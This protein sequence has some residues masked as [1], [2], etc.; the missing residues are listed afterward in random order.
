MVTI[1][2]SQRPVDAYA[3]FDN[4]GSRYIGS[5]QYYAG[6]AL[7]SLFGAGER[8]SL[9]Y[10]GAAPTSELQYISGQVEVPLGGDGMMLAANAGYS[11]SRPGFTL[12]PLDVGRR[13]MMRCTVGARRL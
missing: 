5:L 10:A 2:A 8:I 6:V 11:H 1:V 9:N 7:N 12:R 13:V 3:G 4:H